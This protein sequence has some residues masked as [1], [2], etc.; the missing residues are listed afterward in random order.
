MD[1]L[2][3]AI[4]DDEDWLVWLDA[5]RAN[6][7]GASAAAQALATA[8]SAALVKGA[9]PTVINGYAGFY[10]RV[11]AEA[12]VGDTVLPGTEGMHAEAEA[13]AVIR[14]RCE[15]DAAA[16]PADTVE[17]LCEDGP[18]DVDPET[19]EPGD[20]NGPELFSVSLAQ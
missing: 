19:F 6:G 17:L 7:T 1:G 2:E 14:P 10:V 4:A 9:E 5:R 12:S 8:N 15:F 16:D 11:R 13:I 3:R 20:L 18:I